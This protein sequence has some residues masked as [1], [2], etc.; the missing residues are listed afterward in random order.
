MWQGIPE[1]C[2]VVPWGSMNFDVGFFLKIHVRGRRFLG[3][4]VAGKFQ[5]SVMWCLRDLRLLMWVFFYIRGGRVRGVPL[6]F[7]P[8]NVQRFASGRLVKIKS[9]QT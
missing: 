7:P 6:I 9:K 8:R 2:H 1:P 4:H 5:N 3:W